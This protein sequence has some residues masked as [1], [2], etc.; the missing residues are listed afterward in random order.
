VTLAGLKYPLSDAVLTCD[1]PLGV[2]NEFTGAPASVS[3]R[4]GTL[5]VL[6]RYLPDQAFGEVL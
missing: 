4:E 5:L 1:M 6:W 3:V 2:S